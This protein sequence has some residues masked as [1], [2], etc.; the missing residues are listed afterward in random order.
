MSLKC[1]QQNLVLLQR[2]EGLVKE[3]ESYRQRN[4]FDLALVG[5]LSNVTAGD[6]SIICT[7]TRG[8]IT[9]FSPGASALLGY[10]PDEIVGVHTPLKIHQPREV[11]ERS[12]QL[13]AELGKKITGFNVFVENP[14]RTGLEET[15]K[16]TYVRKDGQNV[17]VS[18]S[19][20]P[21]Y[22]DGA[23]IIGF[24][25]IAKEVSNVVPSV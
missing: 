12:K 10:Q 13:E 8:F 1:T 20:K 15:R 4:K 17:K 14:Q 18:L 2:L 11:D 9:Y 19:V 25:G 24:V 5:V 23:Q 16:W 21:I 7:D 3:N 6:V 22:D